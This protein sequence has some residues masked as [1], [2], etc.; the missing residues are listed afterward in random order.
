MLYSKKNYIMDPQAETLTSRPG[1][2]EDLGKKQYSPN[3]TKA[4]EEIK[5]TMSV[6]E[7]KLGPNSA[8]F[9]QLLIQ[10]EKPNYPKFEQDRIDS[11]MVSQARTFREE[12]GEQ[13]PVGLLFY[14]DSVSQRLEKSIKEEK[15]HG[16]ATGVSDAN[17]AKL[18]TLSETSL[19]VYKVVDEIVKKHPS[20]YLEYQENKKRK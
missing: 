6:F 15:E 13:D 16:S 9:V 8:R 20:E 10:E 19:F 4:I 1:I 14:T 3:S 11:S 7:E 18:K 12:Y 17:N 2:V 5:R